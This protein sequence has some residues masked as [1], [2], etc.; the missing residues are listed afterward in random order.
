MSARY[1]GFGA[2]LKNAATEDILAI[3][4]VT[5]PVTIVVK[6][7]SET[8]A[9]GLVVSVI[10]KSDSE[11][12]K[13]AEDTAVAAENTGYTGNASTLDFTGQVLNN[14]P[15]VPGTVVVE[16]TTGG[17]TVNAKDRDGDGILY[18]DDVDEDAC[19]TIN[20]FTGALALHYPL[21]KDPNTGAISADY[22]YGKLVVAGGVKSMQIPSLAPTDEV[23]YVRAASLNGA[24]VSVEAFVNF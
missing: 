4:E 10:K 1:E 24:K 2:A 17:N 3:T 12:V 7:K 11:N 8:A 23:L 9:N 13:L 22:N 21:G 19:G 16:P 14:L 18:T 6:N 15:V 5:G 20:Y